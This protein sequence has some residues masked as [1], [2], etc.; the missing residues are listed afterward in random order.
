MVIAQKKPRVVIVPP[1]SA[2]TSSFGYGDFGFSFKKA[3]KAVKKTVSSPVKVVKA[4]VGVAVAPLTGGALI[5]TQIG[6]KLLPKNTIVGKILNKANTA[7]DKSTVLETARAVS[8]GMAVGGAIG[9]GAWLAAPAVTAAAPVVSSAIG[10]SGLASTVGGALLTG[11]ASQLLGGGGGAQGGA[12]PP[13]TSMD[14]PIPP[15]YMLNERGELVPIPGAQGAQSMPTW[16]W[17]AGGGIGAALTLYLLW[18]VAKPARP[19]LQPVRV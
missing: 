7:V 18:Q 12:A 3:V 13:L 8:T 14:V 10:G 15:G 5:A 2:L 17:W 9:T 19:A 16:V 4:A 1:A 6:S 11:T